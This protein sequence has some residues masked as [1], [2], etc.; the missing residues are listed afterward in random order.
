MA[1]VLGVPVENVRVVTRFLGSGFGGKL[2]PW[3]QA[4]MAAV[5]ARRLDRPVKLSP[6]RGA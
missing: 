3:P 4:A 6:Q 1:Q 2:F 5:A